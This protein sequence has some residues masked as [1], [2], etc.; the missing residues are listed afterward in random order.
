MADF[1]SSSPLGKVIPS[2]LEKSTYRVT[3][4][5]VLTDNTSE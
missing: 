5:F 1:V 3:I 4:E 2:V